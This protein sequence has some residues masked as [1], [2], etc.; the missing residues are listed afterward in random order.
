MNRYRGQVLDEPVI[1]YRDVDF[2]VDGIRYGTKF[3]DVYQLVPMVVL[4]EDDEDDGWLK[5]SMMW[6]AESPGLCRCTRRKC[7]V[8][9]EN[10]DGRSSP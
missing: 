3:R 9:H 7:L 10:Y 8:R 5:D 6:T 4:K 1:F 2:V